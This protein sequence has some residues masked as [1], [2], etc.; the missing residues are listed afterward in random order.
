MVWYS[1]YWPN[2]FVLNQSKT[3]SMDRDL[4]ETINSID[5]KKCIIQSIDDLIEAR[6]DRVRSTV[7]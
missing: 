6:K 1:C 4:K 3:I 5:E 2:L 7:G